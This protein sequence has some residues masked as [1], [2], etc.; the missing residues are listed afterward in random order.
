MF[1][2]SHSSSN[3]NPCSTSRNLMPI[4]GVLR[5]REAWI[6]IWLRTIYLASCALLDPWSLNL[7][8]AICMQVMHLLIGG[9]L[10]II[11]SRKSS[12]VSKALAT[13]WGFC[14]SSSILTYFPHPNQEQRWSKLR[15]W[16]PPGDKIW[17]KFGQNHSVTNENGPFKTVSNW[18]FFVSWKV[19]AQLTKFGPN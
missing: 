6:G 5:S 1:D 18:I 9:V 11:V 12:C 19:L 13:V 14:C 10:V 4:S 7:P 16:D 2:I 3:D 15:S 17:P 8:P